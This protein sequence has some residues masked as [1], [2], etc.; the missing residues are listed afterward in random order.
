MTKESYMSYD[1]NQLASEFCDAT[2]C[3]IYKAN[4]YIQRYEDALRCEVVKHIGKMR[5]GFYFISTEYLKDKLGSVIVNKKRHYIWKTI[6]EQC[7]HKAHRI[8]NVGNNIEGK[9]TMIELD[10]QFEK[11]LFDT[12]SY[13]DLT[14]ELYKDYD[15]LECDIIPVS[16]E[17]L[18]SFIRANEE[19]PSRQYRDKNHPLI[20]KLDSN[21]IAA[22]R[23]YA[24][25]KTFDGV[26]PHAVSEKSTDGRVY[27]VG[28][29]L[30]TVSKEV[31]HAALGKCYAYDIDN[32]VVAVKLLLLKFTGSDYLPEATVEYWER[33][34]AVRKTIAKSVFVDGYNAKQLK[35]IK[36]AINA[37]SFGAKE[38]GFPKEGVYHQSSLENII[39]NPE[40]RSRFL[41]HELISKMLSEQ[42][43]INK[44]ITDCFRNRD[45]MSSIVELSKDRAGKIKPAVFV[46]RLYN[47]IEGEIM[48]IAQ[49]ESERKQEGNTLLR[50]HDCLYTKLPISMSN[51]LSTLSENN[52]TLYGK[53]A[54]SFDQEDVTPWNYSGELSAA[55][56]AKLELQKYLEKPDNNVDEAA[57]N[58]ELE[59]QKQIFAKTERIV[60]RQINQPAA[61]GVQNDHYDGR[62]HNG[63]YYDPDFDPFYDEEF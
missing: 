36:Q 56:R 17:N 21:L 47:K 62:G 58:A 49:K 23:L 41:N 52:Y 13:A 30:Q 7:K 31:R 63:S 37:I 45:D 44:I 28:T 24:V 19:Q 2:G 46:M 14:T 43:K 32:A 53:C 57:V 38:N 29:N 22:K 1:R 16:L 51:I 40:Q 18:D 50:V 11:M 8:H 15:H 9:L 60:N 61:D 20:K 3:N 12:E 6:S 55:E 35:A 59:K 25:A 33:K 26:V 27:Y 42:K 54:F 39:K 10:E 34:N 48:S 5:D 4:K